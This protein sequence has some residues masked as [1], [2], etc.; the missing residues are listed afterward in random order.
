MAEEH[1]V[2]L[3]QFLQRCWE[4]G[5]R[6][7]LEKC[8]VMRLTIDYLG[9]CIE[10]D[11]L[12]KIESKIKAIVNTKRPENVLQVKSFVGLVNYY[13]RFFPNLSTVLNPI[14]T[15]EHRFSLVRRVREDVQNGERQNSVTSSPHAVR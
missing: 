5:L 6:L 14:N 12:V 15:K 10:K 8:E 3:R 2:K 7:K 1:L 11:G 4:K 13:A 9:Y